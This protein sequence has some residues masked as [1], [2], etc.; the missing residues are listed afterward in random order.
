RQPRRQEQL[1]LEEYTLRNQYK[2]QEVTAFEHLIA[3]VGADNNWNLE[4]LGNKD[5]QELEDERLAQEPEVNEEDVQS[6]N[7][8]LS[9]QRD[10]DEQ[11]S[12]PI[13]ENDFDD[14]AHVINERFEGYSWNIPAGVKKGRDAMLN[15]S[16]EEE[17]F[18]AAA[19]EYWRAAAALASSRRMADG[20]NDGTNGDVA[21][22]MRDY[23]S[24]LYLDCIAAD[25][26]STTLYGI[27]SGWSYLGDV[28]SFLLVK[29]SPN[30]DHVS[31]GLWSMVSETKSTPFSYG[32]PSFKSVDCSVS[33]KGVFTA[34]FNNN[35][36][37][38]PGSV[39]IPVGIRYDPETREWTSIKTSP[40]YGWATDNWTHM[41]FY[42]SNGGVESLVHM[43]TDSW[44]TII[45]FGVLNEAE[46]VLQLASVWNQNRTPGEYVSGKMLDT[47]Q[48]VGTEWMEWIEPYTNLG[49]FG[50][51]RHQEQKK[52][53]YAS[54]HLYMMHYDST[55]NITI[56]SFPFTDPT[57][58]P[59]TTLQ[60][61]KGPKNFYPRYF[62]T[63]T[64]GNTTFLGGLG[65]YRKTN[66]TEEYNSFTMDL[67]DGVPQAPVVHTSTF[68]NHTTNNFS[69]RYGENS[70]TGTVAIH[71]N[72]VTVG[73]RLPGQNPFVVGLSS[74]GIYEFSIVGQNGTTTLGM[75]EVIVPGYFTTAAHFAQNLNDYI[76]S[77]D[78]KARTSK[79]KLTDGEQ[80]GTAIACFI[81]LY[82][83]IVFNNRRKAKNRAAAE[84]QQQQQGQDIELGAR[85]TNM[86]RSAA[87]ATTTTAMT[88][89]AVIAY[90][91]RIA[92][93]YFTSDLP[94]EFVASIEDP[95][96]I[97]PTY[98]REESQVPEYSQQLRPNV[99]ISIGS[100]T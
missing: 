42:I 9:P 4:P 17:R 19:K 93:Q 63:G 57:A 31:L 5:V 96:S 79:P 73:G 60:T 52:M 16:E 94:P 23:N 82:L 71:E 97:P 15:G 80:V 62:F 78:S 90:E 55:D 59:S 6:I 56:N 67:V 8:T 46:S 12:S 37:L 48:M 26:A 83:I 68:Y 69:E 98:T 7:D 87:A 32:Q 11:Y 45:R 58:P 88:N 86:G 38:T 29:T 36:L 47:K 21:G 65:R 20:Q 24:T 61:F 34:F 43:F 14:A 99:V 89:P 25:P 35:R 10:E 2:Q 95:D 28:E 1:E 72:L 53:I 27:T 51:F 41:S 18:R 33:S 40:L 44:N 49:A 3:Q 30:P 100:S 22:V 84:A 92:N 91:E 76:W 74:E 77:R 66:L 70:E 64:R 85:R 13:S 54:G 81:G 50:A 75:V 39:S